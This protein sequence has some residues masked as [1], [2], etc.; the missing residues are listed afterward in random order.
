MEA[1]RRVL[2]QAC[3]TL[4][5]MQKAHNGNI[6]GN[7]ENTQQID[8]V[9]KMLTQAQTQINSSM[10]IPL[11]SG[12]VGIN[13]IL[14][15]FPDDAGTVGELSTVSQTTT[16]ATNVRRAYLAD[17]SKDE[18]QNNEGERAVAKWIV[19]DFLPEEN[20]SYLAQHGLSNLDD[21]DIAAADKEQK[22][23]KRLRKMTHDDIKKLYSTYILV[24]ILYICEDYGEKKQTKKQQ[25]Q[26]KNGNK[27]PTYWQ[28]LKNSKTGTLTSLARH[29]CVEITLW[30]LYSPLFLKTGLIQ[31][32]TIVQ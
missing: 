6:E 27:I 28:N 11:A 7:V 20:A 9:L 23:D 31:T 17:A 18:E 26:C 15:P 32:N 25:Q 13:Q 5:K 21:K 29:N 24:F 10:A 19:H 12:L 8:S 16:I 1:Q 30:L 14:L 4:S 22:G 2:T 3:Q